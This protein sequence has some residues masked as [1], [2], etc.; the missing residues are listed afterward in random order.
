MDK[1]ETKKGRC[2]Y[3]LCRKKTTLYKCKYCGGY[4]CEDHIKPTIVVTMKDMWTAKQPDKDIKEK[5]WREENGHP[6]WPYSKIFWENVEKQ[7]EEETNVFLRTLDRL[8]MAAMPKQES[9]VKVI[10]R[11]GPIDTPTI[12]LNEKSDSKNSDVPSWMLS[13]SSTSA[14]MMLL[15]IILAV[16]FSLIIINVLFSS[17]NAERTISIKSI[18][19]NP[20]SYQGRFTLVGIW[21]PTLSIQGYT[22]GSIYSDDMLYRIEGVGN[23]P[24]AFPK[25]CNGLGKYSF[26]GVLKEGILHIE[27]Y[28]LIDCVPYRI[29]SSE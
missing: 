24:P 26:S 11:M 10:K 29:P 21:S 25:N 9:S 27:S 22:S 17:T 18:A 2:E 20:N 3:H 23:I 14:G 13:R 5:A 28:T 15:I 6:C 19:L 12:K 7:K 4:F 1:P 16:I 8:K